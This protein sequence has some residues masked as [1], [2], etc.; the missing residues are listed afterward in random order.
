MICRKLW[1]APFLLIL[2]SIVIAVTM[3]NAH[4]EP[5]PAAD[6]VAELQ[7]KL[8]KLLPADGPG[9]SMLVARDGK[10]I[11]SQSYG[12]ADR[13]KKVQAT[14]ETAFRIG[15]VTKQFT[16]AAIL[17]L[18]EKGKLSLDDTLAKY[19]PAYPGGDKITLT[20]LLHHTSGLSNYTGRPDFMWRVVK[21]TTPAELLDWCHA[22]A[23]EF[24]PGE[25]FSYCNTGYFLLGNIIEKASGQTRK[26]FLQEHFFTPLGMDHTGIYNNATP[27]ALAAKGYTYDKTAAPESRFKAAT[28]WDMSWAGGAGDIFSTT[29][30][31]LR[32]T[33]ALHSGRIISPE[34]LKTMTT[35]FTVPKKET[36]IMRY[37]MGLYHEAI[38][39]IPTIGHNGGLHGFLSSLKYF[40]ESKLVIVVLSNAHEH[41]PNTSPSE[42][43]LVGTR[44]IL[45]KEIAARAPKVDTS[46]DPKVY[47]DYMGRYDYPSGILTV[48]V[49]NG[50]LYAHHT[51]EARF[52]IVPSAP[53]FF[54]YPTGGSTL[55]FQREK[56][57]GSVTGIVHT[58]NEI[59]FTAARLPDNAYTEPTTEA[60]EAMT[61]QYKYGPLAVLTV[62]RVDKQLYAQLTGQPKYPIFPKSPT[63]FIWKAAPAQVDF[64][65]DKTGVIT[66]AVH[67]QNGVTFTAPRLPAPSKT[68]A[69]LEE[70][71]PSEK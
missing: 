18:A 24:P 4:C 31:L 36:L 66:Q 44:T 35:Q 33:E 45:A 6:P 17:Y 37:G 55:L 68:N 61:G 13:E 58:Y 26:D 30:D 15:S 11:F 12:L 20:Q 50:H 46:I 38:A 60:L 57:G 56:P 69:A 34:S 8:T 41:V 14:P 21:P 51:G 42:I 52:E 10:I 71:K 29:A 47:P 27:P 48:T 23:P 16:A 54:F 43:T 25:Q 32:W 40:P 65:P 1:Q 67:H 70:K 19:Y 2:A 39:G 63:E 64:I 62:T 7:E 22:D 59:K 5:A 28:D 3:M 9:T 49:E 53:D